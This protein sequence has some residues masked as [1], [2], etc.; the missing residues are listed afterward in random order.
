VTTARSNVRILL[1]A[2]A[3]LAG[4]LLAAEVTFRIIAGERLLYR[5][6]DALEYS[7]EPNQS[8]LQRGARFETN[9]LGMR[10]PP[11]SREKPEGVF[12]VLVLGDSVVFG[13]TN[14]SQ[15]DLATTHISTLALG[16]GRKIEALNVSA[17]SW[18]PG[19]LLAWIEANGL[20]DA[21][22]AI[23]VLSSHDLD[24]DRTFRPP[25]GRI[26]PQQQPL[27]ALGDW[28]ARQMAGTG[29]ASSSDSRSSQ[30]ARHSLPI[31]IG[32]LS[33]APS[34]AC[35]VVH[36]TIDELFSLKP[37]AAV[38]ELRDVAV[39]AG[40]DVIHARDLIS[41]SDYVDSIHLSPEGQ[42]N[43]AKAMLAC[44]ALAGG[45]LRG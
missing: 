27:F 28:I 4:A 40:L 29:E 41:S 30:D 13:H 36:S 23:V 3:V 16:D 2:A 17:P 44:P 22:A 9:E 24:D 14:I 1:I 38:S 12:R 19:N 6:D 21:D 15:I 39:A 20:L 25:D 32:R 43:L 31:L 33:E 10:S 45:P 42:A 7:P 35:L 26:Y 37:S 18:G 5:G 8:V 11:A 34:G